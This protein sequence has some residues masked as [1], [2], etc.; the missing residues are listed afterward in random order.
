MSPGT[1]A[2]HNERQRLISGRTLRSG[3][4]RCQRNARKSAPP[5]GE[6]TWS[7]LRACVELGAE[8]RAHVLHDRGRIDVA[9]DEDKHRAGPVGGPGRKLLGGKEQMMDPLDDDRAVA[10]SEVQHAL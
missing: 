10:S 8:R 7:V 5:C 4:A 3:L 2:S 6:G 9:H 1:S